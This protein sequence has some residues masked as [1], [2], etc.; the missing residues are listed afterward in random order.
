MDLSSLP[1][2][3]TLETSIRELSQLVTQLLVVLNGQALIQGV[4][5]ANEDGVLALLN[6]YLLGTQ[7]IATPANPGPFVNAKPITRVEPYMQAAADAALAAVAMWSF[8][9]LMWTHAVRNRYAVQLMLP[10]LL[11]AIV[12]V[13]FAQPLFQAAVDVNNALCE[14]VK[15]LGIAW[16]WR[17]SLDPG[18]GGNSFAAML[19]VYAALFAGYALLG[20]VYVVRYSLL[21]VLAI[22]APLA[23]LL[24][25]LP[26][27]H[28]Y[29]RTWSAL[30]VTTLFMQPLQLLILAV[31]FMLDVDGSL[32]IK[33]LFAL[34]ALYIT[35]KV[36][37]A[38]HFS[39]T[40]AGKAESYAKKYGGHAMKALAKA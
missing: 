3:R 30:F 22:T 37:G 25:V 9:R 33:H 39:S 26:E 4:V 29:A 15:G 28:R 17:S 27:T 8:Y 20:F 31:G 38:L 16:D 23:A 18:F 34:A 6:G 21:V 11:L 35:F 10:R 32:P 1:D 7:D 14:T 2:L 24:F 40:V 36:P 5:K 13:N 12:L 19:V